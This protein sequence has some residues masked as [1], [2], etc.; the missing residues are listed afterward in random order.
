MG[1]GPRGAAARVRGGGYGGGEVAAR[2]WGERRR[3]WRRERGEGDA[4]ERE[5]ERGEGYGSP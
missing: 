5:R 4:R 2:V 3:R 1:G